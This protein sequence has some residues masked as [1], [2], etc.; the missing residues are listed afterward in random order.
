MPCTSII[1]AEP[2]FRKEVMKKLLWTPLLVLLLLAVQTVRVEAQEEPMSDS[3]T[4]RVDAVLLMDASASMRLSD[5]ERLRDEGA[6][7]FLQFL[8]KGDRLA[9]IE[10]DEAARVL[11]PLSPYAPRQE[12]EIKETLESVGNT[13]LYTDL[14]LGLLEARSQLKENPREGVS[15]VI[16]LLSD[17]KLDPNPERGSLEGLTAGLLY[18]LLP[19]LKVDDIVVHTLA[20]SDEADRD[21]LR[22]IAQITDGVNW[23]TPDADQIHSS[24]AELFLVVKKPQ[25]VPLTSKGFRIDG[26]VQE[27]TF[28]INNEGEEQISLRSPNGNL[29]TQ[30]S[31]IAGMKWFKGTKYDTITVIDPTVG[32]WEVVGLAKN[33]GFATVLTKLKLLTDWPSSIIAGNSRAL[34][35]RLYDDERPVALPGMTGVTN[36]SF[37]ITP[38]DRVS[39]PVVKGELEDNG[40]GGDTIA[41]DGVFSANVTI[42]QPGEYRLQVVARGPTFERYQSIP[43][44]VKPRLIHLQTVSV[45][46]TANISVTKEGRTT[47][48]FFRVTLNPDVASLKN[49]NVKLIAF[50]AERRL[51]ELPLVRRGDGSLTWEVPAAEL[52]YDGTYRL[53]ASVSGESRKRTRVQGTSQV[54]QYTKETSELEEA[55]VE[56]VVI[57][58]K[59]QEEEKEESIL[60]WAL[61]LLL[62]NIGATGFLFQKLSASQSLNQEELPDLSVPEEVLGKVAELQMRSEETEVDFDDPRFQEDNDLEIPLPDSPAGEPEPI[63]EETEAEPEEGGGEEEDQES[64]GEEGEQDQDEESD[65]EKSS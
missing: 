35:A 38:T 42:E 5:P 59:E 25:I 45:E 50:D 4:G 14:I 49:I 62:S 63:E 56:K 30:D 46:D 39:E 23:F 48:D 26:D 10:F 37:K 9:I 55:E 13:G 57:V 61:L 12:K 11:R 17:G 6:R 65:E 28:Y 44:R 18:G 32:M 43:F 1:H 31:V 34:R 64:S 24:F 60:L 2:M 53:Q 40:K 36:Y 52:P 27:A 15:K 22:Q 21:L 29:I 3:A 8:K 58:K 20:F 54:I 51:I 16:I 33:E 47:V 7:L 19:D 41:D